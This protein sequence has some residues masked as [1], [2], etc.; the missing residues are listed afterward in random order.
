MSEASEQPGM[1][2]REAGTKVLTD[3]LQMVSEGKIIHLAICGISDTGQLVNSASVPVHAHL[4]GAAEL[5]AHRLK[6]AACQSGAP[7]L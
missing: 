3:W 4:I 7:F 1:S 5:L 2:L 6:D